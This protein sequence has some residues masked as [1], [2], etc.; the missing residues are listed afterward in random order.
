MTTLFTQSHVFISLPWSTNQCVIRSFFTSS[1]HVRTQSHF[2]ARFASLDHKME[3]STASLVYCCLICL[4]ADTIG[5]GIIKKEFYVHIR[6]CFSDALPR[7]CFSFSP[8]HNSKT[9][10]ISFSKFPWLCTKAQRISGLGKLV[11]MKT[12]WS[13]HTARLSPRAFSHNA[14]NL[15]NVKRP[16]STSHRINL[17]QP[18][19][20]IF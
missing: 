7:F 10:N 15:I 20:I 3:N 18:P 19:S 1:T 16:W 9:M 4:E 17:S 2:N 6:Q 12:C 11:D 5:K 13:Q 8:I 14:V